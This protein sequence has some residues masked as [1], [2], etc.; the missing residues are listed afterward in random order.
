MGC[1]CPAAT[2][3]SSRDPGK[4]ALDLA[5]PAVWLRGGQPTAPQ[6]GAIGLEYITSPRCPC[7]HV[8]A[9]Y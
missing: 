2:Q 6:A 3:D 8:S 4:P 5:E 1:L 9:V 7:W